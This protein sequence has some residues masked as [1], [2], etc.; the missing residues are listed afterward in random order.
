MTDRK[1]PIER[2]IEV[3]VYAPLGLGLFLKDV[4]PSLVDTV[5]ARGRAEVDRRHGELSQ[6]VTTARSLGEVTLAF[7]LPKVRSRVQRHVDEVRERFAPIP[8]APP[9]RSTPPAAAA[10][11]PATRPPGNGAAAES[12]PA[13][14]DLPIPGYDALSASQV[15]ERLLGLGPDE[16]AAVREYEESHR[17]RRTILGKI[18]QL[19]S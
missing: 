4:G 7:G 12:G 10:P 9:V 5:V 16:L 13:S 3:L 14:G 17:N 6:R 1:D 15:V 18:E 2:A 19:A 8:P 11:I